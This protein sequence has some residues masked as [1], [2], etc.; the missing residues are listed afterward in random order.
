[1]IPGNS[2]PTSE[3][4]LWQAFKKGD[5][6]AFA[7]LYELLIHDLLRYGY[8]I[9]PDQALVRDSIHDVFLH[10]WTHRQ[11][12]SDTTSAKFY[13]YRA[14]RNRMVRNLSAVVPDVA[15][16][17]LVELPAE[18]AWIAEES[19]AIQTDKLRR[20]IELLP[21]RQQEAIQLR[22]YH[23]FT[24][25]EIAAIME[26]NVQSV[27]N[28]LHRAIQHLRE[29]LVTLWLLIDQLFSL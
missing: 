4:Q 21:K 13:L 11:N 1:M 26:V 12:L 18:D 20:Q 8:R 3:V 14:L 2:D 25:D 9:Q 16:P 29:T 17:D 7:R 5:E 6:Q 15:L 23:D 28:F 19:A 10:L 27:R 24:P 22:Y